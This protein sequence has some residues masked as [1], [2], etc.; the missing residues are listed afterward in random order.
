MI[1]NVHFPE[2]STILSNTRQNHI[3]TLKKSVKHKISFKILPLISNLSSQNS[4]LIRD[5]GQ[6]Y[7]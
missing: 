4:L 6:V 7:N 5:K 2:E 1:P 3:L